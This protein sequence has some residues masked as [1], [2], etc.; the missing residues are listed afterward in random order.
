M[1]YSYRIELYL[2]FKLIASQSPSYDTAL[3]ASIVSWTIYNKLL[4]LAGAVATAAFSLIFAAA[5]AAAATACLQNES[6]HPLQLQFQQLLLVYKQNPWIAP[7]TVLQTVSAPA[8]APRRL[9]TSSSSSN[10]QRESPEP[11]AVIFKQ[12]I[13]LHNHQQNQSIGAN[14]W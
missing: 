9:S 2:C 10:T 8:P 6:A 4:V 12:R 7:A 5:T 14:L 11:A 3:Q 1:S 13:V